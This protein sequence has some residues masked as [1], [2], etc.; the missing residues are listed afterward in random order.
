MYIFKFLL[1]FFLFLTLY[2]FLFKKN[3]FQNVNFLK[4]HYLNEILNFN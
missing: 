3:Y 1:Y 2:L 4:K